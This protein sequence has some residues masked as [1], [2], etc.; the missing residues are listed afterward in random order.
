M[1]CDAADAVTEPTA[2]RPMRRE[3]AALVALGVLGKAVAY[4]QTH[5]LTVD[6]KTRVNKVGPWFGLEAGG[7][8][9]FRVESLSAVD[10]V[11]PPTPPPAWA[12]I[13]LVLF[14]MQQW[15]TAPH[16]FWWLQ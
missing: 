9:S 7:N 14:S 4:Q 6:I 11:W 15:V 8:V 3:I 13:Y 12:R 1:F 16:L 5:N 2:E 10:G